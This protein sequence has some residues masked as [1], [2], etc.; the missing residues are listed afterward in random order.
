M[1]P[2][3]ESLSGFP[4]NIQT[5][6]FGSKQGSPQMA[7]QSWYSNVKCAWQVLVVTQGNI[8][9][10]NSSLLLSYM[11]QMGVERGLCRILQ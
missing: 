10:N 3:W 5:T 7:S 4:K 6:K 9:N 11:R 1:I 2:E 8:T